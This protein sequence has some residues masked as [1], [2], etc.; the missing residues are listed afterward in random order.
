[1]AKAYN[2]KYEDTIGIGDGLNDIPMIEY[3]SL[4]VAMKN[5]HK[6]VLKIADIVAPSNDEEGVAYI[7]N[8]YMLGKE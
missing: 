6:D 7:I 8:K 2:I 4:G 3:A 1:M 5:A